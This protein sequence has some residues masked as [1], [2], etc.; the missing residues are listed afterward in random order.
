MR[1]F[2]SL[3]TI[4][5]FVGLQ[6]QTF[7]KNENIQAY[8]PF[9]GNAEDA[10]GNQKHGTVLGGV[11]LTDDKFNNESSAYYF[12][13]NDG[14]MIIVNEAIA[15][16]NRSHTIS[17]QVKAVANT[18][19][20]S[21]HLFSHGIRLTNNGLHTR[22]QSDGNLHYAFWANDLGYKN[23]SQNS[24]QW[25][26]YVFTYDHTTNTRKAYIDGIVLEES[27]KSGDTSIPYGGGGINYESEIQPIW[28]NNCTSCHG[29]SGNLDLSQGNSYSNLVNVAS[30]GYSGFLRVKPNDWMNSVLYQKIVGNSSFGDPMPQGSS[31]LSAS[32]KEKI[33]NWIQSGATKE[34][35]SKFVIGA[36]VL[37]ENGESHESWEGALDEIIIWDVALTKEEVQSITPSYS[38]DFGPGGWIDVQS[39]IKNE[40]KWS[41]EFWMKFH[42]KPNSGE[43]E[44]FRQT[45]NNGGPLFTFYYNSGTEMFELDLT[46]SSGKTG[47]KSTANVFDQA[48]HH[49]YFEGDGSLLRLY[50]DGTEKASTAYTD[51][52]PNSDNTLSIGTKLDGN[53]D[54]IRI[55]DVAGFPGVPSSRYVA[56]SATHLLFQFDDQNAST[57]NDNSGEN[58]HGS[59]VGQ[60]NYEGDVYASGV[61]GK[62]NTIRMI[63]H[64]NQ[65]VGIGDVHVGIWLGS[66]PVW[67]LNEWFE[68]DNMNSPSPVEGW[69]FELTDSRIT[70]SSGPYQVNAFFDQNSNNEPEGSEFNVFLQNIYTDAKG[71][72]YINIDLGGGG[73]GGGGESYTD[74]VEV[75]IKSVAPYVGEGNLWLAV[76]EDENINQI[77][78]LPGL[79]DNPVYLQRILDFDRTPVINTVY[80]FKDEDFLPEYDKGYAMV[81]WYNRQNEN[82]EFEVSHDLYSWGTFHVNRQSIE[83]GNRL[84][85]EMRLHHI[86]GPEITPPS[87]SSIQANVGQE[88]QLSFKVRSSNLT[89]SDIQFAEVAYWSGHADAIHNGFVE[90]TYNGL[91]PNGLD[92][93]YTATITPYDI[94]LGGLAIGFSAYD[95]MGI[96]SGTPIIDIQVA[97]GDLPDPSLF[98]E[99]NAKT[100]QMVSVPAVLQ[101]ARSEAVIHDELGSPDKVEWRLFEWSNGQYYDGGVSFTPGAAFWLITKNAQQ[102]NTGPGKTTP[103]FSP[104]RRN[105]SDGWNMVGNPY[106]FPINLA[107]H[108]VLS[109]NVE[110]TLYEW[111]GSS[112]NNTTNMEPRGGNWVFSNGSGM[113]EFFPIWKPILQNEAKPEGTV[114]DEED[115]I[116]KAKLITKAGNHY[117]ETATFGVHESASDT[118]DRFDYHEPPVIGNYISMAFDNDSWAKNGGSYSQDIRSEG[119]SQTWN[120]AARSNIK[121]IVSLNLED[122][123]AIPSHQDVRLVDPVLGIVYNLRSDKAVTFTSQGNENPYYFKLIV[124]E[125]DDIQSQL[126][127]MGMVPTDFELFQNTPNP[128]NPVTNIRVSLV[129]DAHITLKVYNLLGKEVNTLALNQSLSKG[130]HRFIWAGKDD[131][132]YQL[133]SGVYLYR[134]EIN[135]NFG[136]QLYQS[137]KKMVLMK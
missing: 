18:Y 102:I 137:T 94:N 90:A 47:I 73:G 20:K 111:N 31:A 21:S 35:S 60:A 106:I 2:L 39:P 78:A 115:F 116:W 108:V 44:I 12:D 131:N 36:Q 42:Q 110:P 75:V 45:D 64:L 80:T 54:E 13:G 81:A 126:D 127:D 16:G 129:Q 132:G 128:F 61:G 53:L 107:E 88:L 133:P 92:Q 63:V 77:D 50:I 41:I 117:D 69:K 11:T 49:F 24:T 93:M 136:R 38:F 55:R 70:P 30:Q 6:A 100:Y 85:L 105:L 103:I 28:N 22:T 57:I 109:E 130:N 43:N 82:V 96:W 26:N 87:V 67:V 9:N 1:H 65:D 135:S 134:I 5:L 19:T 56:G 3:T 113:M 34:G 91:D 29:N 76:Y 72:A 83:Q 4:F 119:S 71:Y 23:I 52:F 98:A 99:T 121:G 86:P 37:D 62:P 25:H 48:F 120:L 118:W 97:F 7:P 10:S 68:K 15:L 33:K 40:S 59:V 125:A 32:D 104:T 46:G 84:K 58:N 101:D 8:Y 17:L 114:N 112:Y 89:G 66:A 95:L 124:G 51:N 74:S 122:I 14:S 123:D 27:Y 79:P